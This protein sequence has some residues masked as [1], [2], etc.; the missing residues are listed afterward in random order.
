MPSVTDATTHALSGL[1]Y[2]EF[3]TIES[4]NYCYLKKYSQ[5]SNR[6]LLSGIPYLDN[7]ISTLTVESFEDVTI[8][9]ENSAKFI[10]KIF[11]VCPLNEEYA[12]YQI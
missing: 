6:N 9:L 10:D 12:F 2:T 5:L 4:S 1:K 11:S 8:N 7:R 3:E